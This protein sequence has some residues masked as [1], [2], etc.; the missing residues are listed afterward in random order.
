MRLFF[1]A[2]FYGIMLSFYSQ[3]NVLNYEKRARIYGS[4]HQ[5]STIDRPL[6][7]FVY[8]K[9]YLYKFSAKVFRPENFSKK[10]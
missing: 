9:K 7:S 8:Q 2:Y 4:M 10:S 6:C 5:K 1:G 3:F